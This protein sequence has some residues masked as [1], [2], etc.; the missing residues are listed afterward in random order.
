[1][2]IAL[3]PQR[4]REGSEIGGI[5]LDDLTL[6][7]ASDEHAALRGQAAVAGWLR[8]GPDEGVGLGMHPQFTHLLRFGDVDG[9]VASSDQRG[10]GEAGYGKKAHGCMLAVPALAWP[11]AAAS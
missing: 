9:R 8:R 4:F 3:R 10:G 2:C 6:G 7:R 11:H 5:G 1:M